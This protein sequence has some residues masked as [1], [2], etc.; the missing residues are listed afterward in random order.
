MTPDPDP[1]DVREQPA[2]DDRP[3]RPHDEADSKG[4]GRKHD[5]QRDPEDQRGRPDPKEYSGNGAR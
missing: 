4:A 5:V 1:T 2:D 3:G